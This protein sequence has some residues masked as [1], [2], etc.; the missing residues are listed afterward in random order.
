ML[1][2]QEPQTTSQ[3]DA[4]GTPRDGADGGAGLSVE[5]GLWDSIVYTSSPAKE[6][7]SAAAQNRLPERTWH[8]WAAVLPL[9]PMRTMA[10][11]EEMLRGEINTFFE[12]SSPSFFR[13]VKAKVPFASDSAS[14]VASLKD[15]FKISVTQI[16]ATGRP[17]LTLLLTVVSTDALLQRANRYTHKTRFPRGLRPPCGLLTREHG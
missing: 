15:G 3:R 17:R 13:R 8:I 5:Q 12:L 14:M 7:A 2:Y 9:A 4:E 6:R 1:R 10:R 16:Q 11:A